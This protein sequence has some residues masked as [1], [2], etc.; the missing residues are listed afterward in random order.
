M[1]EK[2]TQNEH[3]GVF[4]ATGG[5]Q[6]KKKLS[7]GKSLLLVAVTAL[8]GGFLVWG[9]FAT[10]ANAAWVESQYQALLGRPADSGGLAFWTSRIDKDPNQKGV[11]VATIQATTEYK[12]Y[13]ASK[14][15]SQPT[16]APSTSS[17]D[18]EITTYIQSTFQR[19]LGRAPT[20]GDLSAWLTRLKTNWSR[21]Q[22]EKQLSESA[23]GKRY[24]EKKST[25]TTDPN[26]RACAVDA[27]K[28]S[29]SAVSDPFNNWSNLHYIQH[30]FRTY[31]GRDPIEG[32][33]GVSYWVRVLDSCQKTRTE[34]QA[35]ISTSS[36]A[37]TYAA[38]QAEI[39]ETVI[40]P[41][42]NTYMEL[43]QAALSKEGGFAAR[44]GERYN[45]ANCTAYMSSYKAG[46]GEMIYDFC[47]LGVG[48]ARPEL[49]YWVHQVTVTKFVTVDEAI[50]AIKS[51]A[52]FA[53]NSP[54]GSM[55]P[56]CQGGGKYA[57]TS[58]VSGSSGSVGSNTQSSTGSSGGTSGSTGS[59]Q[60]QTGGNSNVITG[61]VEAV[62][63][64]ALQ[65]ALQTAQPISEPEQKLEV[66]TDDINQSSCVV[67]PVGNS[68]STGNKT[69]PTQKIPRL[70]TGGKIKCS[71]STA[72]TLCSAYTET[73]KAE[74]VTTVASGADASN[75]TTTSYEIG[76][77][78][79]PVCEKALGAYLST[80]GY[81]E[82]EQ[83]T[84]PSPEEL[85]VS[86]ESY[87]KDQELTPTGDMVNQATW[88]AL[89]KTASKVQQAKKATVTDQ[90][91]VIQASDIEQRAT[92]AILFPK[93]DD[94]PV[95]STNS[96][97][98]CVKRVQQTL[99]LIARPDLVING[100]FDASTKKAV[101]DYQASHNLSPTGKV[102][103]KTWKL[104]EAAKNS[105]AYRSPFSPVNGSLDN[106]R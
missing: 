15:S 13:Q 44:N 2:E 61:K 85:K 40:K 38:R 47:F 68:I 46:S 51:N 32:D 8:V 83:A 31:F 59:S 36:E 66:C 56:S 86:L 106:K 14:N 18:A 37:K 77:N 5:L 17:S 63:K 11:M 20:A 91:V 48:L 49:D 52:S 81:L 97:G 60:T 22:F 73:W 19:L 3:E 42:K 72:P 98:D 35:A 1:K 94:T 43:L 105:P 87:Q 103:S 101:S 71:E 4:V 16:P 102:D 41:L 21:P 24:A 26:S 96:K 58:E 69:Q 12:N 70:Y 84:A 89:K 55:M 50:A 62:T 30:L 39:K 74:T 7:W 6:E 23:E 57:S 28:P 25:S 92:F 29:N 27:D 64:S 93:C 88:N 95:L 65:V 67:I 99:A 53:C 34:V 100:K 33:T 79:Q 54:L 75:C 45:Y 82:D 78:S 9:T 80:T 10:S 90:A 104:L 76:N